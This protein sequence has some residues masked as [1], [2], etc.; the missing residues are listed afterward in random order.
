M[1]ITEYIAF[2]EGNYY[3]ACGKICI[4]RRYYS[5]LSLSTLCIIIITIIISFKKFF[6]GYQTHGSIFPFIIES[7]PRLR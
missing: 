4:G 5:V 6:E 7:G 1:E 2:L 3:H